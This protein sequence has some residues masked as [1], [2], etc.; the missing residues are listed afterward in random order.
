[1]PYTEQAAF[2]QFFNE[3]NLSWIHRTIAS[4]RRNHLIELLGR[5]FHS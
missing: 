2:N 5:K 3:I 1:M 4:S